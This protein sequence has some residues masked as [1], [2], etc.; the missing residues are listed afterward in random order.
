MRLSSAVFLTA[1]LAPSAALAC[2]GLF[3]SGLQPVP[4]EQTGERILFEVDPETETVTTTVDIQYGGAPDAF[5]W[6]LPIAVND[7]MPVPDLAVTPP[8]VLRILELATP[9]TI[10]P[11]QT[12]CSTPRPPGLFGVARGAGGGDLATQ[13]PNDGGVDVTDLPTVGPFDNELIQSGSAQALIDWLND[14]DYLVTP[15]MEPAIA[16]YVGEGLA[17]LGVKLVPGSDVS[18]IQ[19]LSVTWPGTEPMI[20][21]RLTSISAEPEMGVLVFVLG[22]S[23]YEAIT[24][25]SMELDIDRL[26]SNP[27]SGQNNYHAL[28][29]LQLD[30]VGGQGFITEMSADTT[31][32]GNLTNNIGS[33]A[34]GSGTQE[35]FDASQ[36]ALAEMLQRNDF[37][38]RFHGRAHPEEMT[39]DPVFGPSADALVSGTLDLSDRPRVEACG[40]A[41][42]TDLVP[43]GSGYCGAGGRCATTD[44]GIEGCVC[45]AGF[46]A[47]EVRVAPVPGQPEAPTIVCQDDTWDFLAA[48]LGADAPDPCAFAN[49]GEFGECV[50]V[51]GFATCSCDD[52]FA[53][54]PNAGSPVCSAVVKEYDAAQIG[55]W[56]GCNGCSAS[57]ESPAGL[58]ALLLGALSLVAV[59]R[60]S[61]SR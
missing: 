21:L 12:K 20:P 28:L 43:C 42:A 37:L 25:Q 39:M 58:L 5:S 44:A 33:F 6:I 1:L 34:A 36:A 15:A 60:P 31:T 26:Q 54:V 2:G 61:R 24:W 55:D 3:C 16:D 13:A 32:I 57:P 8:D 4:V 29:S 19:P 52:G 38:T 14:N 51:N 11:P 53:A 41:A 30:E 35:D 56:A 7:D 10:I 17:F 49:C 27:V 48:D 40:N 59:R 18:E 45:D 46:V 23:N 9:P 47:R 22:A 50:A